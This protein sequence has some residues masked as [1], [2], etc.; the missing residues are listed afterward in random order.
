MRAQDLG[1]ITLASTN[2]QTDPEGQQAKLEKALEGYQGISEAAHASLAGIPEIK[3]RLNGIKVPR[4]LD[5]QTY[6][7]KARCGIYGV[8]GGVGHRGIE[9]VGVGVYMYGRVCWH[10]VFIEYVGL[11]CTCMAE[12]AGTMYL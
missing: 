11:G 10:H 8:R 12:Y 5:V 4:A 3:C 2:Q 9:Y 7:C 6:F 1:H